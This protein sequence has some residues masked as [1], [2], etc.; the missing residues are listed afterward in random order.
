MA[1]SDMLREVTITAQ[2]Q[3]DLPDYLAS[4]IFAI[5][6]QLQSLSRVPAG[7]E[8]LIEQIELY[9]TF[10]Q[11]GYLGMGVNHLILEKTILR[12]EERLMGETGC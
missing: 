6:E 7:I 8:D 10:G 9:D 12:V 2:E 5:A 11:T 4:R 3:N 1:L